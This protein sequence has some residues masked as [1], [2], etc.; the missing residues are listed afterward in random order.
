MI[1]FNAKLWERWT[2]ST[3]RN[4]VG[5]KS[6]LSPSHLAYHPKVTLSPSDLGHWISP[7]FRSHRAGKKSWDFSWVEL[8]GT[9][10]SWESGPLPRT[11]SQYLDST[12]CSLSRLSFVM[13]SGSTLSSSDSG[14]MPTL[15][16]SG[17]SICLV[18]SALA[19][20]DYCV[21]LMWKLISWEWLCGSQ[22]SPLLSLSPL[23]DPN[24]V[25]LLWESIMMMN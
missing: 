15:S 9:E 4:R 12:Y 14:I 17:W 8:S 3:W 5:K 24:H 1:C 22:W 10:V 18:R 11:N 7:S 16:L 20:F 21:H 13:Y 19:D 6:N 23:E 25:T 2:I